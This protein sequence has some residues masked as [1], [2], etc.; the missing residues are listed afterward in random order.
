VKKS[1][2]IIAYQI[3]S[4][5]ARELVALELE[6]KCP[7]R[8]FLL[9]LEASNAKGFQI[10]QGQIRFL[11]DVPNIAPRDTFKLLDVS[12]QLYEFRTRSGIRLYCFLS[13]ETLVLLTNGGK[14]NTRKEQNRDISQAKDACDSFNALLRKG[15][16]LHIIEP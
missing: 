12:R 9:D 7:A 2:E 8:D 3:K 16:E 5:D 10:L 15:A 11:S 14:K 4:G 6:G 13:G 1:L